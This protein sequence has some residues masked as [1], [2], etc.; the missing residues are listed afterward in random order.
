[1][2]LINWLWKQLPGVQK[3]SSEE[4]R[5]KLLAILSDAYRDEIKDIA[6]FTWHAERM[7]YPHFRERL[8]RLVAEEQGHVRW[9]EEKIRALG[10]NLPPL[11]DTPIRGGTNTWERLRMD[12]QEE[13]KDQN[14][15]LLGIRVAEQID[16]DIA[17]GLTR[18]RRDEQKHRTELLDIMMK[19][20]P[21]A[22]PQV[23]QLSHEE[24]ERKRTWL[25]Q[26]KMEWFEQKRA[27]W[28]A[29]GKLIPWA[30]WVARREYEWAANEAP[31]R[32]LH[33]TRQFDE[34]MVAGAS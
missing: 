28:E 4:N 26:Q 1:M 3:E 23:P 11:L 7:Y 29:E 13:Q 14:E 10:G 34:H 22:V 25:A 17:E 18:L 30:E 31:N 24:E 20:E 32:E 33:W 12:L 27:V 9:L 8:L 21:D 16:Q 6:N 5:Q 19:S 15:F 2:A